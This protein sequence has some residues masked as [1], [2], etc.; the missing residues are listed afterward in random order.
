MKKQASDS[1]KL[2]QLME[3]DPYYI[4]RTDTD[5]AI[6]QNL[7]TSLIGTKYGNNT[8]SKINSTINHN[9]TYADPNET[10]VYQKLAQLDAALN[11]ASVSKINSEEN[12]SKKKSGK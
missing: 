7:D 11:K 6:L 8:E 4:Q 12:I 1:L 2:Q 10:K 5:K 9:S 3:N